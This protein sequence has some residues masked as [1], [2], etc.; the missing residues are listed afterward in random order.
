MLTASMMLPA[1]HGTAGGSV[2]TPPSPRTVIASRVGGPASSTVA[3]SPV[4]STPGPAS[5]SLVP[6]MPPV[7]EGPP[8]MEVPP[9]DAPGPPALS[10]VDL[11]GGAAS[12]PAAQPAK[13]ARAAMPMQP[14]DVLKASSFSVEGKARLDSRGGCPAILCAAAETHVEPG[15]A[16]CIFVPFSTARDEFQRRGGSRSG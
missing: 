6:G 3:A 2:T 10:P 11:S 15:S 5:S 4:G 1:A 12:T 7:D 13:R 9:V 8:L 14:W 16:A